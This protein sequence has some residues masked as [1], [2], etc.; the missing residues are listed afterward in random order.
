V[1]KTQETQ[2]EFLMDG[3]YK[4]CL[5]LAE[6]SPCAKRGFGCILLKEGQRPIETYNWKIQCAQEI[7]QPECIR[8]QMHSGS[9]PLIGSC[10]HA[11]ELAIWG[12]VEQC[13]SAKDAELYIAG[14]MKPGNEPLI[15]TAPMFYCM[16]CATAMYYAE[17]RGVNVWIEG[18][19]VF[20][21]AQ[22]AYD[23][24][25]SIAKAGGLK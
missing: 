6:M 7:C 14:V 23:S 4:R 20:M 13:G 15:V 2:K 12:S 24:S 19:W 1:G 3:K 22:E 10:G 25:W 9:D 17:V 8:L 16:R 18:R 11:E 5:E 21:T